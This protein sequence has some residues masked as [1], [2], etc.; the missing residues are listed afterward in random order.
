MIKFFASVLSSQQFSYWKFKDGAGLV[1]EKEWKDD[2]ICAYHKQ[3]MIGRFLM[4]HI[5][6]FI[7]V[8]RVITEKNEKG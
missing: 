1:T 3:I 7:N 6:K 4:V 8:E 5:C 2:K